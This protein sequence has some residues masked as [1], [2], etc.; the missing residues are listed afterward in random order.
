MITGKS[1]EKLK[2]EQGPYLH[3][4]RTVYVYVILLNRVFKRNVE[5]D[6]LLLVWQ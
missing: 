2:E 1:L 5:L 6:Y 4:K 3:R